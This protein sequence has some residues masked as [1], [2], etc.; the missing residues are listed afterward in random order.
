[1]V[2][3]LWLY[4]VMV[5]QHAANPPISRRNQVSWYT[6]IATPSLTRPLFGGK[7]LLGGNDLSETAETKGFQTPRTCAKETWFSWQT[8]GSF[9]SVVAVAFP[10]FI[11]YVMFLCFERG[12][13]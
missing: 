6:D 12:M 10:L 5:E 7:D 13:K 4:N 3:K 11:Y 2:K 8:L 9:S 1:M